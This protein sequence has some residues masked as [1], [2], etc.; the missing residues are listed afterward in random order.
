MGISLLEKVF[1]EKIIMFWIYAPSIH[2]NFLPLFISIA[3]T[4]RENWYSVYFVDANALQKHQFKKH[5]L[6]FCL[7]E[8]LWKLQIDKLLIWNGVLH[9]IKIQWVQNYYFENWYFWND[10]QI[11]KNWVNALSKIQNIPYESFYTVKYSWD[12]KTLIS[13]KCISN[14]ELW[15]YS[16]WILWSFSQNP[17]KTYEYFWGI[18]KNTLENYR[19]KKILKNIT[20]ISIP[21][22]K[23][24]II[25]FQVHDDTQ[26]LYNNELIQKMDDILDFFYDDI[27]NI[28]PDHKIIVKEHPMDI[29]RIDYSHLKSKYSDILWIQKWDI[30]DYINKSEYLICVNSSIW[31]QALSKYKK[32]LTLWS[33]FYSN[34]P[35]VENITKKEDFSSTLKRLKHKNII[36]D[37]DEID[38]YIKIF[39]EKIF[40]S[41]GWWKNFDQ[42]TIRSICER[43]I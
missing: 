30:W 12:W 29:G 10:L 24:V 26:I 22:W 19:R 3:L 15:L 8:N 5:A 25:G 42:D 33:N 36:K 1:S 13:W 41:N 28:L 35:W 32:V 40:V 4:L 38:S 39:R 14:I 9:D 18:I 16:Y 31:L 37:K 6:N 43:L 2:T 27:K 17:I 7:K 20:S 23:Y 21:E 34:N 11:F